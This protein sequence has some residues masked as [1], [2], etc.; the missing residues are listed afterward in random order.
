MKQR[1]YNKA[2][3]FFGVFSQSIISIKKTAGN[4]QPFGF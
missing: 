3:N 2:K 1:Y 4:R